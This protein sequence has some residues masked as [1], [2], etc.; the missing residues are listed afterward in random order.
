MNEKVDGWRW[1]GIGMA[2]WGCAG[3]QVEL[4]WRDIGCGGKGGLSVLVGTAL[5]SFLMQ[6]G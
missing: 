2:C 4:S 6:G 1:C 3:L 5:G